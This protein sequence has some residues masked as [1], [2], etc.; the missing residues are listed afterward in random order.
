MLNGN[1][2]D[3]ITASRSIPPSS[4]SRRNITGL[5][6]I[7]IA[8]D[9]IDVAS[10][11]VQTMSD[12]TIINK[13]CVFNQSDMLMATGHLIRLLHR[14]F[15]FYQWNRRDTGRRIRWGDQCKWRCSH[16]WQRSTRL[17]PR[18]S[19]GQS[20]RAHNSNDNQLLYCCNSQSESHMERR[21]MRQP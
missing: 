14:F 20:I 3:G 10:P 4:S 12:K 9:D 1:R 17:H 13:R 8:D 7:K 2:N 19:D 16:K 5:F 18:R 6:I 21:R 11:T 15:K